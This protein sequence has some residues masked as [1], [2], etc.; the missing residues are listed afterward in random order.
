MVLSIYLSLLGE[1]IAQQ[2]TQYTQY[3]YAPNIFNPAYVGTTDIASLTSQYRAQWTG[4][5]GAPRTINLAFSSPLQSETLGIGAM[6]VSESIGPSST[7]IAA[8]DMSYKVS[9]DQ[10]VSLSFGLKGG[11]KVLNI[12]YTK[13]DIYNTT[14]PRFQANVNNRFSPIIGAGIYAYSDVWYVGFS[15]PNLISSDFYDDTNISTA[16]ERATFYLIG[17]YVLPINESVKFKPAFLTKYTSGA[18]LT[19][20]LS[21]NFLFNNKFTLGAGYRL[22]TAVSALAAFQVNDRFMMGY[23]YDFDTNELSNFNSGSHGIFL[24]VDV[25][26]GRGTR[27]LSPRFF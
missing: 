21:A 23:S 19:V 4:I 16:R 22:D 8:A 13:L 6:A 12:D 26:E 15:V 24:K 9:L 25:G 20:D 27:V 18:P 1:T 17:G 5:E 7:I 3:M 11:L 14:D 10:Y 2:D